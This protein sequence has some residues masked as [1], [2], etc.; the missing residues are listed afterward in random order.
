[1]LHSFLLSANFLNSLELLFPK[2]LVAEKKLLLLFVFAFLHRC[3]LLL[4]FGQASLLFSLLYQY[5][6]VVF[7]L[8][9]L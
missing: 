1:M 5:F 4:S 8:Q 9:I 7:V 3:A 6:I 2:V